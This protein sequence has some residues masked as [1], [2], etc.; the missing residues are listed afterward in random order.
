[1]KVIVVVPRD[2]LLELNLQDRYMILEVRPSYGSNAVGENK[3]TRDRN[4]WVE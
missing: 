1:M 3:D 4:D 2:L